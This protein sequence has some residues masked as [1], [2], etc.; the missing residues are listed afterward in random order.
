MCRQETLLALRRSV[1]P[2]TPIRSSRKLELIADIAAKCDTSA[3]RQRI[4]A[5]VLVNWSM[6]ERGLGCMGPMGQRP[7]KQDLIAAIVRAGERT[8]MTPTASTRARKDICS[9]AGVVEQLG[10]CTEDYSD[11]DGPGSAI[12]PPSCTTLVALD[13]AAAPL[14][15]QQKLSK[16]WR[17]KWTKLHKRKIR[18]QR[19]K[20]VED[21]LRKALE[22]HRNTKTVGEL[23]A[24]VGQ[25]VGVP[26]DGRYRG[27]FDRAI[28]KLT[29]APPKKRR[30]PCRY[31]IAR[32]S[33]TKSA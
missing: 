30:A 20:R 33:R 13:S 31:F 29:R 7:R 2:A 10:L 25:A 9:S 18:K 19:L 28:I 16:R 11:S 15:L 17:K 12:E 4:F 3:M 14:K 26:L 27:S 22:E 24:M 6:H 1:L 32:D 5:E 21:E 23:R 8:D